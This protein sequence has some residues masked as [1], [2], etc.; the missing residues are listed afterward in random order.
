MA[1]PW[2]GERGQRLD[3]VGTEQDGVSVGALGHGL[4]HPKVRVGFV[5][6]QASQS[7][8]ACGPCRGQGCHRLRVM[9]RRRKQL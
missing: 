8:A 7:G 3:G 6:P 1:C 2:R 5:Y 9:L 4:P